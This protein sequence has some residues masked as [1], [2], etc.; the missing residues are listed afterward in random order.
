[1]V[2]SKRYELM[3]LAEQ[4]NMFHVYDL[5]EDI[6]ETHI[7]D[8]ACTDGKTIYV[9]PEGFEPMKV[10]DQFFIICHEL[11]HIIYKHHDMLKNDYYKN[12]KLL[13]ICQDVVINEQLYKRLR[14]RPDSG[15]FL[16]DYNR[17]IQ[18]GS[19]YSNGYDK[20]QGLTTK[21]LYDFAIHML[22]Q[23]SLER[24]TDALCDENSIVEEQEDENG[25]PPTPILD[26]DATREVREE[27]RISNKIMM[28][29]NE[30]ME[31]DEIEQTSYEHPDEETISGTITIMDGD[32]PK[33]FIRKRDIINYLS[34]FLNG[35]IEVKGRS[36]TYSRPSRR[37]EHPEL[38]MKGYK[39]TK[40]VEQVSIYLDTSGSMSS[41]FVNDIYQ[42]LKELHMKTKFRMFTFD[43]TITEVDLDNSNN[44]Y[45]GGGTYIDRVLK[46]I[47]D[48]NYDHAI[49]IT[50]CEDNF[51]ID[52][53]E[54]DLQIFTDNKNFT[55][56][57]KSVKVAY[58]L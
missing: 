4:K 30:D 20:S 29:E 54:F 8:I 26:E 49:M 38:V 56:N 22:G 21:K 25:N 43:T 37:Y 45:T 10:E 55:S 14:F 11:M 27:L 6:K 48:N 32:R 47:K 18:Q 39:H 46:H 57:N 15:V 28:E 12:K 36:R 58:W 24:L 53:V 33:S 51:N 7:T 16:E 1:M 34:K 19:W 9:N 44:I 23:T 40:S 17:Y 35:N 2:F 50:D 5:L 3:D 52:D 13:N 31:F 41:V 42:T